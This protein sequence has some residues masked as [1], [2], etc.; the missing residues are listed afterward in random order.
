MKITTFLLQ[1]PQQFDEDRMIGMY[2]VLAVFIYFLVKKLKD[3]KGWWFPK[4]CPKC[5]NKINSNATI[6]QYCHSKFE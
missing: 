6:C 2:V 4:I 5:K 3:N 1:I